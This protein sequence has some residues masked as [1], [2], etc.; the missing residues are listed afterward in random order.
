[1][2]WIRSL[3]FWRRDGHG[4]LAQ[5]D[6]GSS[7]SASWLGRIATGASTGER[8]EPRR[9]EDWET[10]L[11]DEGVSK[12]WAPGLA[13]RLEALHRLHGRGSSSALVSAAVAA[14]QLQA[15]AQANVERNMRD[16]KEVERLLGAF[17]G[18]LEKLDEVLEVLA[19]YAQRM[20]TQPKRK[21]SHT[22]H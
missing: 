15:E 20:R 16:V 9:A 17:S 7:R 13:R 2:D 4:S 14:V 5:D 6:L 18:E 1:M 19:A 11:V 8:I 22:L 10:R 12:E 3:G 21:P